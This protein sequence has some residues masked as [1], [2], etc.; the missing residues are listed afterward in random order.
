MAIGAA[1]TSL[2]FLAMY[3]ARTCPDLAL[4]GD[5]AELVT[6]AALWG[7][8]HPPGYP[9]YTAIGHLFAAVPLGTLPWRVHMT[10][11]VFHAG[12]VAATMAAA[13]ALT[14]SR[15]AAIAAGIGLGLSR[16]FLLGSL[17]AEVFPLNDLLYALTIA[18]ALVARRA[19]REARGRVVHALALSAGVAAGHHMMFAL[20]AP[21][22]A[23]L[24]WRPTAS[25]VRE[26]PRRAMTLA[27]A[28]LAPVALAYVLVP[29]A[30]GRSPYLS[31]GDVH[32][33]P[34]FARLVTRADYGGLFS[35]SSHAP[36]EHG[37]LRV[38]AW[39][40]LLAR[41]MGLSMLFAALLGVVVCLRRDRAAGV[42]LLLAVAVP[43]PVFAW[44]NALDTSTEGT[45]AYF[46]RFT[47]MSHVALA[48]AFGAGVGAARSAISRRPGATAAVA[49][50]LF[51]WAS[52]RFVST[53]DVDMHADRR[54][55]VFA[56]DL[57]LRVPDRSL[58]LLSG[59]EPIDAEL[60]LC[61]VE[62]LCGDRIAFAPGML[63]LPWKMAEIRRRHPDLDIPWT[64]GP[65]LRR[66]HLLVAATHDRPVYVYPDLLEKDPLLA[67]FET[68][69]GSLLL[70]AS[71]PREDRLADD[72]GGRRSMSR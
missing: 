54:G 28:F 67:S 22:V 26:S 55:I 35:P 37:W 62:R 61:G 48:V 8:P 66:T 50:I 29:L 11:A 63:S 14:K 27:A 17:Y 23:V 69:P 6:A 60:Y 51:A 33:W 68:V 2:A 42:G 39:T 10:S 19:P 12:A 20:A 16:S 9:L 70:R 40:H 56:H 46:E 31:W 38:A 18:L 30:A 24:A 59:D 7:V 4:I 25:L 64:E 53:R 71:P 44:L 36:C 3:V 57:L 45:L 47:T 1:L 15:V 58:V 5:S 43:G 13:F 65:A 41:S 52:A 32:D 72:Q 21:A 49:V 34:S